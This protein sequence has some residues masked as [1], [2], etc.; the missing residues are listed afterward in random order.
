M[1]HLFQSLYAS[2]VYFA[3]HFRLPEAASEQQGVPVPQRRPLLRQRP[4]RGFKERL[5]LLRPLPIHTNHPAETT[6]HCQGPKQ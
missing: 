1:E 3:V 4:S 5:H 6:N 2:N